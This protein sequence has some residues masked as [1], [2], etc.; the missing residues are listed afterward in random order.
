[1]R[2]AVVFP[3]LFSLDMFRKKIFVIPKSDIFL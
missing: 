2:Y 1:M 3:S